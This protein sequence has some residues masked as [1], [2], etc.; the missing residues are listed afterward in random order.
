MGYNFGCNVFS[1][2]ARSTFQLMIIKLHRLVEVQEKTIIGFHLLCCLIFKSALQYWL[3][4]AS[5]VSVFGTEGPAIGMT[6][7]ATA[8]RDVRAAVCGT[9]VAG[10]ACPWVVAGAIL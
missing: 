8:G 9:V 1:L 4:Q 5:R 3:D 10:A 6:I 7:G 2:L